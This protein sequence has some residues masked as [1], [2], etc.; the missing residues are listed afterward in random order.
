MSTNVTLHVGHDVAY[1]THGQHRGGC[2]GAMSYYTAAGEPPGEWAGKGAATLGLSGAVDPDVIEHLY[3]ENTGPGG[4]LLVKRRQSRAVSDREEQAVTAYL[5]GHPYAS[6]TELAEVRAAERG[7]D[8]RQVP[9]FDLTVSAVKSVSVLHASYRLSAR[10]ARQRGDQDRAAALDARADEIEAALMDSARE[11]VAWIERHATYTRTGHHSAR[12]GEWRDGAGLTASLFLHHLS[13]DGDPQLHVHVAIWNRVQRADGAD[14]KWR[15]LDS[16][17]LHNQRLAV[18]PVADRVLETKLAAFGYVMVPR[19][20]GNGAEIGGVGQDVKDLFSSRAVAVTGELDRLACEYLAVHGRPPSR[21]TLWLLHQQAGQNTR[22][23]KAQ[24]RR[25]IAGRTGTAEPTDA[26]RLAAWEAQ[27][28][29]REIEALSGVHAQVASFAARQRAGRAPAALDD[30]AKRMAARIAVAEVQTQHAVWSMAQLRFEVHRALPVLEGSIDGPAVV[31]EVTRLAVGGRAGAGVVQITAPDIADVTSLGVRAS[32]GGSIYRPP[33]EERFCTLAHLDTE[34]QILTAAKR[35]VPQ[36]VGD[37][38][39][40]AA[41]EHTGLNA[42]QRA[43]VVMMLTATAATTVLSA[44]AG[45]GKSHTMAG[46]ARLWT[47]FTG[48][49]VIG[50]TTSTNA[51]RVLAHE[52]LAESYNIAEFLGKVEGSDE[53]RRPVPLNRDDVLVLDEASQIS[54]ADLALISEA[55]RQAGARII[56]TGD[57]AQLGAVDAGGMFRLLAKEVTAAELHEV[58]RFDA[59]WERQASTQLRDGSPAA[60]AAYDRYGR[61]RAADTETAYDRAASMWLADYLRDR[62]VLLLAGSNVEAADLARR[63]QAKLIQLGTVGPL[64]AALADG[65]HAGIGDLVRARLNTKIDA[66]GRLLTNRDTLQITALGGPDAEVQRQHLDGTWTAPFRIPRAY[67]AHNVE[68]AYAGNVHVAQGRTV[69]TAHLLVTDSLSRQALYV[70]MTRGRQSNTAHVVTGNTAPPGHEP[71]QQATPESVLTTILGRDDGDL[72]ATEQIRQAQD[73]A[74]GTGHMLTL[75]SAAV[76]QALYLHIDQQIKARLT[77]PEARRYDREPSRKALHQRL[78]TTQLAGHDIST[79][80]DQITT[81]PMDG[82]RSI[83]SVLHGR[84]QRIPLHGPSGHN[85]T[86]AER[87]P[88]SAPAVAHELAAALDTRAQALGDQLTASPEPWLARHLGVLAPS[89][90]PALREEYTRRAAAAA[91][92]REAAGITDS[93]Q[94][95]SPDPHRSSPELEGMRQATIRALE[96][97]DEAEI[98]RGL[99]Q[100]Q[101]EARI[102]DAA[103][104]WASAPPD[105]SG[106]LRL[107]AQAEADTWQQ[108]ADAATR[109]DYAQAAS[110]QALASQVTAERQQLET[111]NARYELWSAATTKTREAAAKAKAELERRG[112]NQ[113]QADRRQPEQDT[114]RRWWQQLESDIAAVEAALEREHQAAS[115][116][117]HPWPSRP[118]PAPQASAATDSQ[119]EG[120]AAQLDELLS[121]VADATRRL[122]AAHAGREARS[123]YAAHVERQAQAEPDPIRQFQ[124][125]DQAEIEM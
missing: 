86:W 11:A 99:T 113:H 101:L 77:A 9:Y 124:V 92:Y 28:A 45:A 106:Q 69:D 37:E 78:R 95:V 8:P 34:E 114:M 98:M 52:G 21:R 79:L 94:A 23:T 116:V 38:Q 25:T 13:R 81:A 58:R 76:G 75:W 109:N 16:R 51:A 55:A 10:Q 14:A 17:S 60:V 57:T 35:A 33:N 110:A 42:E 12:S 119:P 40:L 115:A 46:F 61:I 29:R 26:Q 48:R 118:D 96:I 36:L 122:T 123:E 87:I 41:A 117:G 68:L 66:A 27:T 103:R 24:A 73:W 5:A 102:L 63:V 85:R 7:K 82:A 54:T 91:A 88:A 56:A 19:A 31:D 62:D 30:A 70:G 112:L 1:F 6:A 43:A 44:P 64:Q 72:S 18:A 89:A 3:Q 20:D 100:G 84:L 39:A 90:S 121:E 107:T 74:G 50:L 111:A 120:R 2:A 15:T 97:R 83:A 59:A 4:E 105:V 108:A 67:L 93:Q 125:S 104:A 53:L 71:Y 32:D 80:I 22:R 47:T 65:N 49:R